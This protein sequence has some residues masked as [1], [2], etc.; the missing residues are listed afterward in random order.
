MIGQDLGVVLQTLS[1]EEGI[2]ASPIAYDGVLILRGFHRSTTESCSMT[3]EPASPS[4]KRMKYKYDKYQNEISPSQVSSSIDE[5]N[6]TEIG[7]VNMSEFLERIEEST[8]HGMQLLFNSHIHLVS[9]FLVAA[10]EPEF[11]LACIAHFDKESRT[12]MAILSLDWM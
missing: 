10:L 12:M 5:I 4:K 7:H 6:D 1:S 9:T 3:E 2:M 11:V 8:D